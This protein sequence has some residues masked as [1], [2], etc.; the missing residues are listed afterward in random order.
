MHLLKLVDMEA[1]SHTVLVDLLLNIGQ[2][3]LE[4]HLVQVEVETE[5]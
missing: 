4:I 5:K 3:M 2:L 1:D